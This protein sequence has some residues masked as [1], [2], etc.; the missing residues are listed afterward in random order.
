MAKTITIPAPISDN[1]ALAMRVSGIVCLGAAALGVVALLD[2]FPAGGLS[3]I[4]WAVIMPVMGGA[5]WWSR[6]TCS[7]SA[8]RGTC[9]CANLAQGS[10][11]SHPDTCHGLVIT[12]PRLHGR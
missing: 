1:L 6:S 2:G 3:G 9:G 11:R 8:C 5:G 10:G 12:G 4:Q 7:L